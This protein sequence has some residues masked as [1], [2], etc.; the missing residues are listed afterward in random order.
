MSQAFSRLAPLLALAF[1]FLLP[2][3]AFAG[4]SDLT[5]SV[6]GIHVDATAPSASAAEAIAIDQGRPRAWDVLYKRL[7]KQSDWSKQPRLD[8][9]GLKRIARGFTV[10]HEKRSTTRYVADVTYV[11]SPEA[12]A[13][14][15]SGIST[16]YRLTNARRILLIPMSPGF[17]RGS[18]W[19]NAFSSPRFGA[20]V[21]P[22]AVPTGDAPDVVA[23]ERLQFDATT[24]ADVQLVAA[25]IHASEVVLALAIPLTSGGTSIADKMTGKVQIWLKRIGVA[26]SPMKTSVDVPL[27]KNV[28]QTYPLAADAAVHAIEVMFQQ[29]PPIDF[30]PKTS[31]SAEVHIDSLAQW[32][33][34]QNAMVSVPNVVAVQTVAMDIGLV[35]INL[36]YQGSSDT[37]Q[38]ALAP[39]GVGLTKGTDGWSIAYVTPTKPGAASA[40]SQ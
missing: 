29:K 12:V 24:W 38:S 35:R 8:A 3:A 33:M 2:G 11:F 32:T 18:P 6:S 14:V 23:L 40:S 22:F 21:V 27:V 17:N 13:R 1:A 4:P 19:A 20:S 30:G 16:A 25:R 28:A 15:M 36:T 39:V 5:Y 7:A 37:L 31:L 26:E 10:T 9:A 34:L